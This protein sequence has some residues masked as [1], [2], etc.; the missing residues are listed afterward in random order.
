MIE[1]YGNKIWNSSVSN[2]EKNVILAN[3]DTLPEIEQEFMKNGLN[4]CA[5]IYEQYAHIA[6]NKT[7]LEKINQ[8]SFEYSSVLEITKPDKQPLN[9]IIGNIPYKDISNKKY[10]SFDTD[11][12]LQLAYKLNAEGIPYS[13]RIKNSS[14]I[15]TV[16]K[17]NLEQLNDM[18]SILKQ[19]RERDVF[20]DGTEKYIERL[21]FTDEQLNA[22]EN[23]VNFLNNRITDDEAVE[24]FISSFE[25]ANIYTPHQL[26]LLSEAYVKCYS[27]C[28]NKYEYI[29][30]LSSEIYDLKKQ[31]DNEIKLEELTKN[32]GFSDE[33]KAVI[34][35][36]IEKEV[37]DTIIGVLDYTFSVED[38]TDFMNAL[39]GENPYDEMLKVMASVKHT[40]IY[41]I[42]YLLDNDEYVPKYPP[43]PENKTLER[44]KDFVNLNK[45][46]LANSQHNTIII[47]AFAGPG[48]GKTTSCLEVCEKL[49]KAGYVAEYVQ[50]YAKELVWDNNLELLNGSMENQF[51]ILQEQFKRVDRLYGKV[52]FV[53]TDSPILLN[54]TYLKEQNKEYSSAVIEL[55]NLFDNFNYFVERD[56]ETFETEGR[57]HNLEQSLQID[58]ELKNTLAELELE[59]NIYNHSTIENI[60]SDAIEYKNNYSV[61]A[62]KTRLEKAKDDEIDSAIYD[63]SMTP[64]DFEKTQEKIDSK[65]SIYE[66]PIEQIQP[67]VQTQPDKL[68]LEI[69]FTESGL[70]R[71]FMEEKF[72]DN[73]IPFALGN[74]LIEFLDEKQH[75]EREAENLNV[76]YYD[77][78]HFA[79]SA[80]INGEDYSYNGRSDIGDGKENGE[81]SL[82][83]HIESS[84]TYFLENN[85]YNENEESLTEMRDYLDTAIPYFK[86]HSQLTAEEQK[87]LDDF[88]AQNPII[89]AEKAAELTSEEQYFLECDIAQKLAKNSLSWDEIDDLGYRFFDES[90]INKYP[91]SDK[92]IYGNGLHEPELYSLIKRQRNG[93]DI[94]KELVLGLLGDGKKG[95]IS[96]ENNLF[97]IEFSKEQTNNGFML[98]YNNVQR[99]ITFTELAKAYMEFFRNDYEEVL[100]AHADE[101]KQLSYEDAF[102]VNRE[103][104]SVTWMY[105]NPDSNA[106]GQYVTNTLS[107]D[108]I[109]KAAQ[110]NKLADE[111]FD[112]LGSIAN[113]TLADVGT[114]WF[115]EADNAFRQ[116]PDF[117][118][119]TSATMEA[120]IENAERS[121]MVVTNI[122]NVPHPDI[123]MAERNTFDLRSNP[124]EPAGKKER[125][126]RNMEAIKV[127]KECEFENRFAT[128]EEQIILSKYVGWGGIPEAFDKTKENWQTEFLELQT[129]LT[130]DEYASARASTLDSFFTNTDII[131][132]IY[133]VLE[134]IG[135]TGG[136]VLEPAMGVGNFFGRMPK[137]LRDN[138]RLFG[139]EKDGITGRIAKRLYP[140]ADI[141]ID[142]FENNQY[143]DGCFDVAVG[144]VPFASDTIM[145]NGKNL[146][147]HDYFFAETLDKVRTGGIVA[148]VTSKGTLDKKDISFREQLAQK[149]DLLGAIRLPNNAFKSAGTEATTDIIFL[150]KR[151]QPPKVLPEWVYLGQTSEGLP[152]NK[153][154]AE[155]SQMILG[156]VVQGNKLYGRNDDTM[157][158]PFDNTPLRDLLNSAVNNIQGIYEK[159]Q[160][161][162]EIYAISDKEHIPLPKNPRAESFF[163]Y[164][165]SLYFYGNVNHGGLQVISAEEF[166]NKKLSRNAVER[167]SALVELR[168]TTRE[169]LALQQTDGNDD[170]IVQLQAKLN[171]EYDN[172]NEKYGLICS[173]TNRSLFISDSSY[174]LLSS[175]EETVKDGKLVK[176]SDI[177]T[178]RVN[179]PAEIITS[180][181]TAQ[182]ALIVSINQ[183]GIVDLN[184]M[185]SI[186][187]ISREALIS[188]L[189]GE[190]F[191]V[192]ELSTDDNIVYQTASEYLSGDIYAK[193]DV[194]Q[195]AAKNNFIYEDNCK[196]LKKSI[197]TPLKAGEIDVNLGAT[198]IDVEYYQKFMYE[199][200]ETP[201]KYRA[202]NPVKFAWQSKYRKNIEIEYS[203]YT[204]RWNINHSSVD[205]SV[206]V[207]KKY[208]TADKNAY[209]ILESVLNLTD[210]K[211]YKNKLDENGRI[212]LDKNDNPVRVLDVET[213]KI[214]QQKANAIRREFKNWIFKDPERRKDLVDTYNR[215]FN[216]IKPREYDGSHLTFPGMNTNIE[217]HEH[218]KNAIAHAIYGGNTLF[219]HSVG[220]GK[221][222]EM[223]ATA[224]ECKRLGFCNKSMFC[225]PNHLTEQV[226]SDFLKLYPNANILVATKNDFTKENRLKFMSKIATGNYDAVIIG[227]SQL[228]RLPLS[229]ERQQEI[230]QQQIDDIIEGIAELKA[231]DGSR[232]QVKAME[233]TKKSLEKQLDKLQS[234]DKDNTVY[235]EELGIDKLFIDEAHEFKN[236]LTITKLQNVSGISSR[237]S[238]KASELFMKCRYL[239]EK[240][241]GKGIVFAT[242][243]PISNSVTELHTMMRYLDYDF[244]SSH[245][246]MQNFDNWVSSFGVQK[247]DYELAPAGNKFKERT[248]IAEYA[249]LPE[250]MSMFKQIADVKTSD[251]LD[252][253]VPDCETHIV[254]VEATP[255]QQDMVAELSDRADD[256]NTGS[257]DPTIDNMLKITS[258]GRK[259]GLDPRLIDPDLEDN[260]NTKLNVCVNNTFDIYSKTSDKKLTQI[261]FCDLGV[262]KGKKVKSDSDKADE[263]KSTEELNSLEETGKF[264][265]YDDIRDK[266]IAKGV[267]A[268]EI[269][270]IHNAKTEAQKSELF[271][272]VRS[273]EVRILLGSTGKMGTGTN[274]Q[275]R[276]IALHDLDVPWRPA[277]LEQRRGRMVRQ[278]NI[279]EQVHLYRYVTKGTFDAYS[280]QILEKKQ[281]FISQIMTSKTPARR[282]SDIDQEALSYSE[283]KALC[284]GDERIKEKLTL[285]N[286]V[287]ELTIYKSEY[288]NTK[289]ELEDKVN[290]YSANREKLC[291]TISNIEKDIEKAHT[292]PFGEDKLPIFS[293]EING[294]KFTDRTDAAKAFGIAVAKTKNESNRGKNFK[295]GSIYGFPIS[296]KATGF[297]IAE[298]EATVNGAASY[299][300][301]L[302]VSN[303]ANIRKLEHCILRIDHVLKEQKEKLNALDTDYSSAVE[304]LAKPF[305]FEDELREKTERL[306]VVTSELNQKAVQIKNSEIKDVKT[307]YFGKNKIL[308]RNGA[309]KSSDNICLAQT[310][311]IKQND[312]SI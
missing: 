65:H 172:F 23:S 160:S 213:T 262:P 245:N 211:A 177:F 148:F 14:T 88:K 238:Q 56:I 101:T 300:I 249:N 254:N 251:V 45:D 293:C 255:I 55:Y 13:G 200:F 61:A 28:T 100:K 46:R 62:Q 8:L 250:L 267:P 137:E 266:L 298:L 139:V 97:G 164:D 187:D 142:G 70:L 163:I 234:K 219:A 192:P 181:D 73:K 184:Y 48:A 68:E 299:H 17:S 59:Y 179:R 146:Q 58:D 257:I 310:A 131:D 138:S 247:T 197:P 302:G 72:P 32:K 193:L 129:V 9:K 136:D 144:N 227:H 276:I 125:F 303:S 223:I 241:G 174:P 253:D 279:N 111:F 81:G 305:E 208:G 236:L 304:M 86:E 286:R 60:V 44:L 78:T 98:I 290:N 94:S 269:A 188:K 50:E 83:N 110:D 77:K 114:E 226:G 312:V 258:D 306:E 212:V 151:S 1:L 54:L 91:P 180:V 40:D 217:L 311:A 92:A 170:K 280:Y 153:Y 232:F 52:D 37:S 43:E 121:D 71:K 133:Y 120:L 18:V 272:K 3:K 264:C 205:R 277:D 6:V 2:S 157:V 30:S 155:N 210:P 87:I 220:A 240:T 185:S 182:E 15:L 132:S 89:T 159:A 84:L 39:Y 162:P 147:I 31:F 74:A 288:N 191:P 104:E 105:F 281:K 47:N 171:I 127:L 49:K 41:E 150:Q 203:Q 260:P 252:L 154:F 57:I 103:Q 102:Y 216:C 11:F 268:S 19:N 195:A 307:H 270:Y 287:K 261:I 95:Y 93:E 183:K 33:Q 202:D 296:V 109:R 90:Y 263:D 152:I 206:T 301:D 145:Y 35:K 297:F 284:T 178:K 80:I 149:A 24:S 167:I 209:A 243:T 175:L 124:V 7:D 239:D 20:D 186:S 128:P 198:W 228:S 190:I 242:G 141:K 140:N 96:Y 16:D 176:K 229:P 168:N 237:A 34:M 118:D 22:I 122:G 283:I 294:E 36:M 26:S 10:R 173:R 278:G 25:G 271:S 295:I 189:Q 135:F 256:V 215:T 51:A 273:G 248:R 275:D 29:F 117:T 99:E 119:C 5:Y 224:M 231:S 158:V 265:V 66:E 143:Q 116:T 12:A 76:G 79:I 134:K 64:E 130:P 21:G 282:C 308:N 42:R 67:P 27:Q 230:Y 225:V 4:Y 53:V 194:A 123:P 309:G 221:T 244:L 112:Y 75:I 291:E 222:Y 106:G 218:Q 166:L 63:G 115:E 259:L 233:R 246:N 156:K 201:K 235:F 285:E 161:K 85:Q 108:E 204:G 289:Y 82:I 165:N 113:Q 292:I 38:L 199:L 214:L 196:A 69:G 169:L 126:R 207:T 274:V 107:F